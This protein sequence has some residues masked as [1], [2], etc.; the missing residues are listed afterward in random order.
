M[1]ITLVCAAKVKPGIFKW[2]LSL[3]WV[4]WRRI[5]VTLWVC[6]KCL[7]MMILALVRPSTFSC[8][9]MMPSR[10][11]SVDVCPEKGTCWHQVGTRLRSLKVHWSCYSRFKLTLVLILLLLSL[12]AVIRLIAQLPGLTTRRLTT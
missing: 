3:K 12:D 4:S 11:T 1:D 2:E 9:T 8:S 6:S 7:I 5:A 10:M